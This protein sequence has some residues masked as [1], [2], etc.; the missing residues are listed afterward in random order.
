MID[1]SNSVTNSFAKIEKKID[2]KFEMYEK[3]LD[4][5]RKLTDN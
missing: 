5:V 4:D 2:E 1:L 3:K